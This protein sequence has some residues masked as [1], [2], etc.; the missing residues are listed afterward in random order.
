MAEPDENDKII[1]V[2]DALRKESGN[3]YEFTVE[4]AAI[5]MVY[6]FSAG[7]TEAYLEKASAE[8]DYDVARK[9]A[10]RARLSKK[11]GVYV[12]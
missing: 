6:G 2:S 9:G 7:T 5:D 4:F 8:I 10:T 3:A 12:A 1:M 11:S